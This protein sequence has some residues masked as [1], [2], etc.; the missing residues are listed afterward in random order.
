M[1]TFIKANL[2]K[3]KGQKKIDK[4]IVV[5]HKITDYYFIY[6]TIKKLKKNILMFID[7][8]NESCYC[9]V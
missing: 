2:M 1:T 8:N 7:L 9:K 4:Y 5:V 6:Y 3:A